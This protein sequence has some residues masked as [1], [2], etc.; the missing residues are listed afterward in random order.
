MGLSKEE[1]SAK[2]KEWANSE[3]TQEELKA[4][5]DKMS[6]EVVPVL[7]KDK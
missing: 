3:G 6:A 1:A 7:E 4:S 5:F 2:V